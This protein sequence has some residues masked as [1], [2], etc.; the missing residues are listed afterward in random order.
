MMAT[1]SSS[2]TFRR[3]PYL[4]LTTKHNTS[5]TPNIL[6]LRRQLLL[7]F[8]FNHNHPS[9]SDPTTLP[10]SE[11]LHYSPPPTALPSLHLNIPRYLNS[12][13]NRPT[14][15]QDQISPR[16]TNLCTYHQPSTSNPSHLPITPTWPFRHEPP[17][18]ASPLLHYL[19]RHNHPQSRRHYS[20]PATTS[21]ASD[22]GC[23]GH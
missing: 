6:F 2:S 14:N 3:R 8:Q 10:S 22:R 20:L 17:N 9:I 4:P 11:L 5:T 23:H 21:S 16:P 18:R 19:P 1:S 12:Q 15:S 13:R 7:N